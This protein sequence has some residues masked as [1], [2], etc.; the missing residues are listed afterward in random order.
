MI[1]AQNQQLHLDVGF[2]SS[3]YLL[4]LAAVH[5]NRNFVGVDIRIPVVNAAKKARRLHGFRNV[6][7]LL[8]N[9]HF[10]LKSMMASL[11]PVRHGW[12]DATVSLS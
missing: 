3:E 12:H 8:A 4:H 7:F 5:P 9:I 2:G 6:H 11:P 1:T 10:A